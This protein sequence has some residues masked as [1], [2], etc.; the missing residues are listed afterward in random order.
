MISDTEEI[1]SHSYYQ[2][3]E[4]DLGKEAK[5]PLKVLGNSGEVFYE[6]ALEMIREIK[7]NNDLGR[8]TVM[9]CPVGPVGHYSVFTRLVNE[10]RLSLRKCTF[11]NMDEY[12]TDNGEYIDKGSRLSFRGFM[13][14]KVYGRIDDALL[15][16]PD[17]R[18]FPDPHHP[19]A[20][21]KL[22][23]SFGGVDLAVGGIGINGHLAFNE[24]DPS[25]SAEEFAKLHTRVLDSA[26]ETRTANAIGD[27]GGALEDM[28]KKCITIGIAEILGAR[29]VRLGVFRDWHRAVVRRAA[30]GEVSAGFPV[31]LLQEHPDALIY[32]NDNAAALP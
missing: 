15:M 5:I 21:Q 10:E 29:K 25:L 12:L 14:R 9:I 19:E 28:P 1:M 22:I 31:T 18:V 27:L 24:A 23:D 3:T 13:D 30:Y 26:P 16:S 4:Q 8:P 6:L 20:I 17:R 7:K 2:I 11:I 32:V